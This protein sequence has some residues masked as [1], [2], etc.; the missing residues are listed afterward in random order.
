MTE[1][2]KHIGVTMQATLKDSEKYM[3]LENRL[4]VKG[5]V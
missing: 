5:W 2:I 1:N 4:E 3:R